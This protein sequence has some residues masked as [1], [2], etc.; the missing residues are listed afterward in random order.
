MMSSHDSP[1]RETDPS[2]AAME[3]NLNGLKISGPENDD[4]S[5]QE[6]LD[7]MEDLNNNA[8]VEAQEVMD[9]GE[10]RETLHME[11]EEESGTMDGLQKV[12]N[13]ASEKEAEKDKEGEKSESHG[14]EDSEE[15]EETEDVVVDAE[16]EGEDH[17]V[18]KEDEVKK[19]G[20]LT[21]EEENEL[22]RRLKE[23]RA[24]QR[25]KDEKERKA[26]K[27]REFVRSFSAKRVTRH[28]LA[29]SGLDGKKVR[30]EVVKMQAEPAVNKLKSEVH[31]VSPKGKDL[32]IE[33]KPIQRTMT[34]IL[35]SQMR[36][37]GH[38]HEMKKRKYDEE[39]SN[40][41]EDR[42]TISMTDLLYGQ[43]VPV[44]ERA[45][46]YPTRKGYLQA[47]E[48]VPVNNWSS[49]S[50]EYKQSLENEKKE[51]LKEMEYLMK[52]T[53]SEEIGERESDK[54]REM[55]DRITDAL[56]AKVGG[57]TRWG[58]LRVKAEFEFTLHLD[59]E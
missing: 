59:R 17:M 13:N 31:K 21:R 34:E 38:N 54:L 6:I 57:R 8:D 51:C 16:S 29:E 4:E 12:D 7:S 10:A 37:H 19:K 42:M 2:A 32:N 41:D 58:H 39:D 22:K 27:M 36:K 47:R 25:K 23:N 15:D 48:R 9:E 55:E 1:G 52:E 53:L 5:L 20:K 40:D 45:I 26:E 46:P 14:E 33:R 3:E 28:Q 44:V 24:R 56:I 43:K 50:G 11:V 35:E 18:E 49:R 30:S